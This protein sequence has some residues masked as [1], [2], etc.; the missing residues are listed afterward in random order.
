MDLPAFEAHISTLFPEIDRWLESEFP[1]EGCGLLVQGN[2]GIEWVPVKNVAA[3]PRTSFEI[4]PVALLAQMSSGMKVACVIHSHVNSSSDFSEADY[5]GATFEVED[6]VQE[7]F[8]GT[9]YLVVSVI[10]GARHS[11]KLYQFQNGHY[12]MEYYWQLKPNAFPL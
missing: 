7:R 3:T 10:D 11:A 6:G 1:Q 8:P 2:E 4:D 9:R 12:V 5:R